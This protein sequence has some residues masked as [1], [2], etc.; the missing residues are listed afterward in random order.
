MCEVFTASGNGKEIPEDDRFL[1]LVT[2]PAPKLA[3]RRRLIVRNRAYCSLVTA[4]N[5]HQVLC[6]EFW[7]EVIDLNDM[8]KLGVTQVQTGWRMAVVVKAWFL[9][10]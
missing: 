10:S 6:A 2:T 7:W 1:M 8:W 9:Q 4:E 5:S 3:Q